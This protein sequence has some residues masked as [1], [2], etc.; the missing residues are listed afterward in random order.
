MLPV[1]LIGLLVVVGC[2]VKFRT[3]LAFPSG[4][5]SRSRDRTAATPL[6][7]MGADQFIELSFGRVHYIYRSSSTPSSTL[8]IFVHG[9]SIPM[10]IWTDVFQSLAN[11]KSP[12]LIFDLYGRG[13][14]DSPSVPM[15][16]D[17][18]VSQLAE[19]LYALDLPHEKYH[20]FGV[21]MGGVIAQRFTEL[22]PS[23]VAK[24]ILCCSAGLNV[25]QPSKMLMTILS[26]PVLG[27]MLFKLV[28]Q[29]ADSKSVRSQWAYPD[30]DDYRRYQQLFQETCQQHPGYLRALFSTVVN[31]DFQSALSIIPSIDKLN[32]P[33]LIVWGD[34][35][36]LIP[37]DCAYRYHQLYKQSSLCIVPGAN[38][39]LLIEHPKEV[40]EAIETFLAK[41]A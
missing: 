36:A 24:L 1:V 19:L 28:M 32:I 15:N 34:K 11:D 31:F 17:L 7:R 39:S 21:S 2:I 16:V 27:P 12:C 37:V 10:Q 3:R 18:F 35:D 8:N 9:F 30:K 33:V 20:L 40:I 4:R 41:S 5:L 13:W 26:V 25:V 22:Y 14:S 23:K 38:H 29:R 6:T